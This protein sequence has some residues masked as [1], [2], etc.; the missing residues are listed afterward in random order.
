LHRP[1]ADEAAVPRW[2]AP[3]ETEGEGW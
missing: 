1:D 3:D 2:P